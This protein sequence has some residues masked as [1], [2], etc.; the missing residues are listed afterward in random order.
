VDKEFDRL[1][2]Y[3]EGG[4]P[5]LDPDRPAVPLYEYQR[6]WV[7]D[8]SRF[9][10]GLWSRQTGKSFS[11]ALEAVLDCFNRK[12][13][14]VFLSSGERQSRELIRKARMHVE[15]LNMAFSSTDETYMARDGT[16]YKQLEIHLPNGSRILALPANP[17]TAR[18]HSANVV[19]DEFAFHGDSRKIWA[20]LFPTITKGYKIR[21]ISTP[22]GRKNKFYELWTGNPR[23]SKHEVNIYQA[24]AGGMRIYGDDMELVGPEYL[25]EALDDEEAWAQEYECLF[26]DEATAW[27]TY[28]LISQAEN[29][30]LSDC[31]PYQGNT[32]YAGIDIGRI[33]DITVYWSFEFIGDVYWSLRKVEIK[34]R[35]FSDQFNEL[36][37]VISEDK[38]RRI[39]VDYTGLGMQL[40]EDLQY[41]LGSR[42][43][44]ITFRNS[45]KEDLAVTTKRIFEDRRIR[46]PVD[47]K[48]REDIHSVKRVVTAAGNSRFDAERTK[49]GHADRFWAL[50]LALHAGV[51]GKGVIEIV[52]GLPRETAALLALY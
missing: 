15:A 19:L 8:Q 21:V 22:Q 29:D 28:E 38:P 32:V 47:R 17:D 35:R 13:D 45:V 48:I 7:C 5:A 26:L 9:K 25:R 27:I 42:V 51:G 50:A 40:G 49:D 52:T 1:C 11:T 2:E 33:K 14:W 4:S 3:A 36:L 12:T 39:C 34:G 24:V 37:A 23:F 43:E 31:N 20:A 46:L 10:L 16:V 6:R 30:K 18:G 44:L 41:V